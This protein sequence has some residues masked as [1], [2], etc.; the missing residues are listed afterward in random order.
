MN[1]ER[2]FSRDEGD[3]WFKRNEHALTVAHDDP[4]KDWILKLLE[5]YN[6][7]PRRILEIGCSN[8][9]RLDMLRLRY[10]ATCVG[11][12]PS[13]EA[14]R[15]G[16][17]RYPKI[18]FHRG[19]AA[20]LPVKET[21][22]LVLTPFVL[23]WVAREHLFQSIAE[24]DRVLSPHGFLGIIDF[25]PD[26]PTRTPYHYLPREKVYTYKLDYA[27]IFSSTA[28]YTSVARLTFDH[29]GHVYDGHADALRRGSCTLLRK[30][31]SD[32]MF[33]RAFHAA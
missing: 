22:D 27:Q 19:I 12:E 15:D 8:G 20:K 2:I 32:F 16:R 4:S 33:E 14:I 11:I 7:T 28:L 10:G 29:D 24:I 21:F 23:H 5:T 3:A 25:A 6:I 18:E 31:Y 26:F 1:Q 13:L 30:S 9:W 17:R